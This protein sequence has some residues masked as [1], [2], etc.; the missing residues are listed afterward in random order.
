MTLRRPDGK[1][2]SHPRACSHLSRLRRSRWGSGSWSAA[3]RASCARSSRCSVS[4]SCGLS[5]TSCA[6]TA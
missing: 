5:L 6:R 3:A 2:A 1:A 4:G